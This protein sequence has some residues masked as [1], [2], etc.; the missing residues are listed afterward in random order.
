MSIDTHNLSSFVRV[1]VE[2]VNT[3]EVLFTNGPYYLFTK[4]GS[5]IGKTWIFDRT[6]GE[7]LCRV[8]SDNVCY[9]VKKKYWWDIGGINLILPIVIILG[10][11]GIAKFGITVFKTPRPFDFKKWIEDDRRE[12][13]EKLRQEIDKV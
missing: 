8:N 5:L 2:R 9:V 7:T 11:L 1:Y 12:A 4:E 6:L 10:A 3:Y 13:H